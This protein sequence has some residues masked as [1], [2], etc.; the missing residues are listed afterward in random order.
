M[1][2]FIRKRPDLVWA[3]IFA[4][5]ISTLTVNLIKYFSD[6]LRPAAV[7]DKDLINIIGPVLMKHSFLSG[8][9]VTIF[10]LAGL[11]IFNFRFA[12]IRLLLILLALFVGI[13]RIAVGA[14]W[15]AD[16]FAGAALGSVCAAI[17]MYSVT[18]LQLKGTRT[19]QIIIGLILIS[20]CVYLL[21]FYDS[22]YKQ[23]ICLKDFL[24]CTVLVA[25]IR[26]YYFL[27][28]AKY[29]SP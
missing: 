22:G 9:T 5:I 3:G 8:H 21:C 6:S 25:G 14:H 15:P 29:F 7:I 16:V 13:S 23:T 4:T 11:L 1:L 28:K 17:A 18:K 10:T 2:L 20:A 26:E 24:A 19:M 27:L 12:L